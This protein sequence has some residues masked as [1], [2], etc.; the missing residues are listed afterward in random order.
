M[1][2]RVSLV[3]LGVQDLQRALRFYRDGL[4]WPLSSASSDEIAFLRTGGVVLALFPREAL[5]ADAHVA[6]AGSGFGG[7]TLAHNVR[8]KEVVDTVLAEAVAAGGTLLKPAEEASWGGYAGYFADP[9]GFP[10]EVA[11]NPH[12]PLA[13]DGSLRLPE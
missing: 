13:P 9:D 7:M 11:W 4:G 3:T 12:F 10:W 5:A 2:A 6:A 8:S 1:E